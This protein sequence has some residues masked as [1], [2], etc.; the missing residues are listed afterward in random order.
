M[1][2][3]LVFLFLFLLLL[4]EVLSPKGVRQSSS[5]TTYLVWLGFCLTL[6]WRRPLLYRN[7]S[8]GFY[9]ITASAMKGLKECSGAK[10]RTWSR[11]QRISVVPSDPPT[12]IFVKVPWA[13]AKHKHSH[14]PKNLPLPYL[15]MGIVAQLIGS[16][17]QGQPMKT[18]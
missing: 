18:S 4:S 6:S 9:M 7:Q 5:I 17:S 3:L 8:T 11:C 13:G 2:I 16:V 12:Q 14:I 1:L 10:W 15:L